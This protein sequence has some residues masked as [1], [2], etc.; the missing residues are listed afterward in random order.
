MIT[1]GEPALTSPPHL[2]AGPALR[3]PPRV[4]RSVRSIINQVRRRAA[5]STPY[6]V[7]ICLF[8]TT[9]LVKLSFQIPKLFRFII[10]IPTE[11][12]SR[13]GGRDD[14]HQQIRLKPLYLQLLN[15]F[16]CGQSLTPRGPRWNSFAVAC[17]DCGA[18]G[19]FWCR[20]IPRRG[21]RP[22]YRCPL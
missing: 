6:S 15:P 18:R 4:P 2:V 8:I 17:C 16:I 20:T 12:S 10:S 11:I 21:T 5:G 1:R 7:S 3:P 22:M 19:V 13:F 9:R 14:K